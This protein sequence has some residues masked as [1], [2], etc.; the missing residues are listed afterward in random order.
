[1]P[2]S[3]RSFLGAAM[4]ATAGLALQETPAPPLRSALYDFHVHLFGIGT[5]GTGCFL[6]DLVRENWEFPFFL[7]LLGL[8]EKTLDQD[9]VAT[10]VQQLRGSSTTKA[11]LLAHDGRYDREGRFDC[12]ATNVYVP[13]EYLFRVVADHPDLFIPC[14]S[15]NPKRRDALEELDR[16]AQGGARVLKIHPPIQDVDPAEKRFRPFYRR[17]TEHGIILMVHTGMEPAPGA[18]EP[19]VSDPDRL[20][21]ALEEGCTVIAAHAGMGGF[22]DKKEDYQHFFPNLVRLMGRF[23]NL[24]CDTSFI[25]S[26]LYWRAFP[27]LLEESAVL[28]RTVYASDWPWPSNALVFWNRLTLGDLLSL[29]SETNLFERDYRLKQALGLPVEA[30]GRGAQLLA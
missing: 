12:E 28:E 23:P 25:A 3:R 7:K 1:M 24:Y 14:A 8:R 26:R 16:C 22:F 29:C 27:R 4:A 19:W 17:L 11:V 15:I 5:G 9:Y 13:N 10:L 20:V 21:I 2:L 18:V 30:F 6:S